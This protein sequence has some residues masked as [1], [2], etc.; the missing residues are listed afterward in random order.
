M[1]VLFKAL[2]PLALKI[3]CSSKFNAQ[4]FEEDHI[5]S[6]IIQDMFENNCSFHVK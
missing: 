1:D 4:F 3:K 6:T 5:L 2:D